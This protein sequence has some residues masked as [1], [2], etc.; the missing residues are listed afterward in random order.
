MRHINKN[1]LEGGVSSSNLS[2]FAAKIRY[3]LND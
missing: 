2:K 1:W 3:E